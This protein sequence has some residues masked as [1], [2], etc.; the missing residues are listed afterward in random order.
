MCTGENLGYK[1]I[2]YQVDVSCSAPILD[3][4]A[5]LYLAT[6]APTSNGF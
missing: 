4:A 2:I 6:P 3:F 1:Y 5:H